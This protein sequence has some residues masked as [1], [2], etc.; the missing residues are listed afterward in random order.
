MD[1]VSGNP[2]KNRVKAHLRAGG[3]SVSNQTALMVVTALFVSSYLISNT[4]AVKVIGI[5]NLFYF[6]NIT[7]F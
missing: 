4:M 1:K 6:N 3:Q 2:L 5:F 7:I